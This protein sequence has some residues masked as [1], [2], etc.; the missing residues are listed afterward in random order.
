MT[1]PECGW[2]RQLKFELPDMPPALLSIEDIGQQKPDVGDDMVVQGTLMLPAAEEPPNFLLPQLRF[3]DRL[4]IVEKLCSAWG[5]P[6]QDRPYRATSKTFAAPTWCKARSDAISFWQKHVEKLQ[7]MLQRRKQALARAHELDS[8]AWS[9]QVQPSEPKDRL[10]EE[11]VQALA[12]AG[13]SWT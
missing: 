6:A 7:G 13:W 9:C 10:T 5:T 11:E 4:V 8:Q 3:E 12:E 1:C 2:P